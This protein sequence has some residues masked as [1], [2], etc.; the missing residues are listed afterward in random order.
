TRWIWRW[1]ASQERA[2]KVG[3]RRHPCADELTDDSLRRQRLNA[4]ARQ[5]L[6][7][8]ELAGDASLGEVPTTDSRHFGR[9]HGV[10][11]QDRLLRRDDV[12]R[13]ARTR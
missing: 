7:S 9:G 5:A 3:A 1:T 4:L 2:I 8:K 11:W 6:E 10:S 12:T 13:R